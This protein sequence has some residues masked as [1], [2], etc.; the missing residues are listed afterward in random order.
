LDSLGRS[1]EDV[2][3][4]HTYD[5]K[6]DFT[7]SCKAKDVFDEESDWGTLEISMP[8]AVGN[9]D[10]LLG[11]TFIRGL[12]GNLKKIGNDLYFR[13]IRLHYLEFTGMEISMG[14]LR[15]KRCRVNDLGY[16]RQ[17]VIGPLGS[18]VWIVGFCHGG[19]TEL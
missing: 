15:L 8:F 11:W 12:V 1:G 10:S 2:I 16:D 13:T 9:T 5:T 19:L 18:L 4:S 3:V 14:V 7:I 17:M 6:G